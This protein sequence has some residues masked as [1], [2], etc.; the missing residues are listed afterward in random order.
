MFPNL[1]PP[2]SSL[3]VPSLW[4]VPVHQPQDGFLNSTTVT[5][6]ETVITTASSQAFFHTVAR[7]GVS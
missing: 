2:S 7:I 5:A 6:L 1:N 3:P 4:V